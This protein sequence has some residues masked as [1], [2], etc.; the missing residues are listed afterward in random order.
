MPFRV[1]P[2]TSPVVGRAAQQ[3]RLD[4]LAARLAQGRGGA[5]ALT[6]EP[7]IGK[8]AL[9]AR[10][11]NRAGDTTVLATTGFTAETELPFA[12][13][14]D[15]LPPLL[16]LLPALPRPQADALGTALA[17]SGPAG[18]VDAYAVCMATLTLLTAAATRQPVLVV[19]DDAGWIDAPSAAALLFA[20]RRVEHHPVG[21][22]FAARDPQPPDFGAAG[23]ETVFLG[24]L[25]RSAAGELLERLRPGRSTAGVRSVLVA[26]RG[27]AAARRVA[28]RLDPAVPPLRRRPLTPF[29]IVRPAA[30]RGRAGPSRRVS[31]R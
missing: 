27:R 20:A 1:G 11:V 24:G 9:L 14:G 15:L 25:D 22:V 26:H 17:L 16:P 4:A 6:G 10:L 5:I 21:L 23:V 3:R 31:G 18:P 29:S 28:G 13:L 7:G 30:S 12:A 8:T 19:V 2:G